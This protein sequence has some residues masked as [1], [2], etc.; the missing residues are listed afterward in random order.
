LGDELYGS[1]EPYQTNAIALHAA[2]LIIKHP[3]TKEEMVFEAIN[4][5]FD[6][7]LMQ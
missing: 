7:I 6:N 1:T 2:K 3:V 4:S 5:G